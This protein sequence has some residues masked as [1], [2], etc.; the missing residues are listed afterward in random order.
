VGHPRIQQ[1]PD[2]AAMNYEFV[3]RF[4]G[5]KKRTAALEEP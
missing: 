4:T 5:G 2:A 3:V 1:Q